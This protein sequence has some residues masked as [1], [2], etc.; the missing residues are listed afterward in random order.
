MLSRHTWRLDGRAKRITHF[1]K[2]FCCSRALNAEAKKVRIEAI[3]TGGQK[4]QVRK[5]DQALLPL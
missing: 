1:S 2:E 5:A 3:Y 4:L